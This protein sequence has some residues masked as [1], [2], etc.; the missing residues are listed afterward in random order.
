MTRIPAC[1]I[2]SSTSGNRAR[3]PI[4]SKGCKTWRPRSTTSCSWGE[5]EDRHLA[6]RAA[7]TSAGTPASCPP[8]GTSRSRRSCPRGSSGSCSCTCIRCSRRCTTRSRSTTAA[9]LRHDGSASSTTGSC[10]RTIRTSGSPSATRSGSSPS[11]FRSRSRWVSAQRTCSRNRAGGV[12]STERP[13]SYRRMVPAVAAALAFL[14]LLNAG[15]PI[16]QHAGVLPPPAA[17]VVPERAVVQAGAR[18]DRPLG[19]REHDDHL[20]R[21]AAQRADAPLR[22]RRHRRRERMAEVPA[23]HLA[24]DQPR[25][26]LHGGDRGDLRVPVLHRGLCRRRERRWR[27]RRLEQRPGF[28]ARLDALLHDLALPAGV[29]RVPSRLR[30]RDGLDA[31]RDRVGVHARPDQSRRTGGSST[32]AD[33]GER[34][35]RGDRRAA[36]RGV[37]PPRLGASP[38]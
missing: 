9:R 29:R 19:R 18:R 14:F 32:K 31:L 37:A 27:G 21:G 11:A 36:S 22:G 28:S 5:H 34:R 3:C 26:L 6:A 17:V 1:G 35:C 2:P 7:G 12:P 20:P 33:S 13:S 8:A 23:H 25:D 24:D 16:D 30:V 15:G 4:C 38:S 10:S